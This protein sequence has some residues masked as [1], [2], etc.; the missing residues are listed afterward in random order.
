MYFILDY[1]FNY[2]LK[3]LDYFGKCGFQNNEYFIS[4]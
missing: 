3:L 1:V 2:Q 4:S